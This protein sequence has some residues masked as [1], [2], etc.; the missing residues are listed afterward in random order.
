ME[1]KKISTLYTGVIT[2]YAFY[3][4]FGMIVK[5]FTLAFNIYTLFIFILR[6]NLKGIV[7]K[8]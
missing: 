4:L 8:S 6:N 7:I 1:S 2:S 3:I 5:H